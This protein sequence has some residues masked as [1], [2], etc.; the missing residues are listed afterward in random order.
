M[1]SLEGWS[2]L[3]GVDSR[4]KAGHDEERSG[5]VGAHGD[6]PAITRQAASVSAAAWQL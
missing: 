6:K 5:K 3:Y 1:A 2:S 4:H